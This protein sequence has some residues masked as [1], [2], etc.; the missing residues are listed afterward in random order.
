MS[1]VADSNTIST[2]AQSTLLAIISSPLVYRKLKKEVDSVAE[3]GLV[4]Y[5][6]QSRE[7]IRLPFPPADQLRERV[8]P[9]EGDFVGGFRISG[10]T[11]IALNNWG[12]QQDS[13]Y[14]TD[15]EAFRPE[16]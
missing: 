1:R 6:I 14:G 15:P 8:V 5:P 3:S 4:A 10:G 16:R 7:A 2:A 12:A 13:V 11:S 9:P